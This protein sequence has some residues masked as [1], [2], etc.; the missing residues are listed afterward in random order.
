MRPVSNWLNHICVIEQPNFDILGEGALWKGHFSPVILWEK[1]GMDSV[2]EWQ[3]PM[4]E[5]FLTGEE[6]KDERICL[7]SLIA[8]DH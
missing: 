4:E 5:E 6:P 3:L 2:Q 7:L 8:K 1:G